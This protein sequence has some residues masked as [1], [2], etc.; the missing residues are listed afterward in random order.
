[1]ED[2]NLDLKRLNVRLIKSGEETEWNSLMARHHY[3]GFH[4]LVGETLKYIAECDGKWIALLGWGTAA[5]KSRHRDRWIGW[6]PEQQW[7]RLKYI[8]NNLRFLILPEFRVKNLASKVLSLN[9]KCLSQD[10][11]AVYGHPVLIMETFVD[12]TR[13]K[14]TCYLAANWTYLGESRGFARNGGRWYYHGRPKKILVRALRTDARQV[15]SAPVWMPELTGGGTI[16]L[17]LKAVTTERASQLVQALA[18]ITDPRKRRGIRHSQVSVLAIAVCAV[19]SG[20]RSYAAIGEWAAD[21][22]QRLLKRFGC[23]QNPATGEYIAPSEPTLR[24]VL[25]KVDPDEVDRVIGIW[26][27]SQQSGD[28]I[29]IDGKALRGAIGNNGKPIHLVAAFLHKEGAVIAQTQVVEKSN[30]ITAIKPLLDPLDIAG[31]VVT[32][33]A[34]HTQTKTAQYLKEEK[35]ADYVLFVKGNQPS[36]LNDIQ[37]LDLESFSPSIRRN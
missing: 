19:L 32:L 18:K 23:R 3:L 24:R 22:S 31:K 6:L 36:L 37:T 12:G 2:W 11:Q 5:F 33:D 35:N 15:L 9:E 26:I 10:W 14:G 20:C 29:A 21:L 7:Q 16:M 28:A 1:M 8:T 4:R 30:E 27:E 34:L 25:Q 17:N 13:F